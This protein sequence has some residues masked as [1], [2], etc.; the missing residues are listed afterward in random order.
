VVNHPR[1]GNPLR[2]FLLAVAVLAGCVIAGWLVLMTS[3]P[4]WVEHAD[5]TR[6]RVVEV[7]QGEHRLPEDA[8]GLATR[9]ARKLPDRG[10]IIRLKQWVGGVPSGWS[11]SWMHVPETTNVLHLWLEMDGPSTLTANSFH[12]L[13]AN[14]VDAEG[15]QWSNHGRSQT[16][17]TVFG[18]RTLNLFGVEYA[19]FPRWQ[20][21]LELVLGQESWAG[22]PKY[23]PLGRH[24]LM[25]PVVYTAPLTNWPVQPLPQTWNQDGL[26]V[27]LDAVHFKP[28]GDA[29]AKPD[30]SGMKAPSAALRWIATEMDGD[31]RR[32][33]WWHQV[34]TSFYDNY[35]NSSYVGLPPKRPELSGVPLIQWRIAVKLV[36]DHRSRVASNV[37]GSLTVRSL[38][39]AGGFTNVSLAASVGPVT[40]TNLALFGPGNAQYVEGVLTTN[41]PPSMPDGDGVS[42]SYSSTGLPG[43]GVQRTL[44]LGSAKSFVVAAVSGSTQGIWFSCRAENRTTGEVHWLQNQGGSSLSPSFRQTFDDRGLIWFSC[45]RLDPAAEWTLTLGVHHPHEAAFLIDRPLYQP[46]GQ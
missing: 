2:R 16:T 43:G 32:T 4:S 31:Q 15:W 23:L 28:A 42:E 45:Q 36:G 25:N 12:E 1:P 27:R 40:L 21:R 14:V 24:V 35:G 11:R 30:G 26:D 44:K 41:S 37:F 22:G 17:V 7:F 34:Q 8:G 18:G 39:D 6:T 5:G 33:N 20:E 46:T 29:G 19:A 9:L 3:A 38:P 10:P 13:Q